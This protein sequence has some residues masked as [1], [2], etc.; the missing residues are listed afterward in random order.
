[1]AEILLFKTPAVEHEIPRAAPLDPEIAAFHGRCFE[2]FKARHVARGLEGK[3]SHK[4]L[5]AMQHLLAWSQ[6]PL[7]AI[8]ESDYEAWCGHLASERR[9]R[10][11]T[12]RTYQKGVR[13][14]IKYLHGS[15]DLQN[16][17]LRDF[18]RRMALFAHPDNSI[19]HSVEDESAGRLRPMSH[20]EI[21]I[22]FDS[23]DRRI[24]QAVVEAPRTVRSLCRD[25]VVFYV[26]YLYGLRVGEVGALE[27]DDWRPDPGLPECGDYAY[28]S[29][30]HGKGAKGS[31]KRHRI[32]PTTDVM[33]VDTMLWYRQ[34]VHTLYTAK[35]GHEN[36]VFL[37]EQGIGMS[38]S[39]IQA[40]FALHL[41]AAGFERDKFSPHSLRRAMVTHE[42][43]RS[44]F[45][46]A[47]EKVG[48]KSARTTQ[49]YGQVPHDHTRQVVRGLIIKQLDDLKNRGGE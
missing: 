12:Q 19:V 26:M 20:E 14:V 49:I 2:R 38:G 15:A 33:L 4:C 45:E 7:F 27:F 1:M 23:I 18:G 8:E 29:V 31:G 46:F 30:R 32:V 11:S 37:S 42:I 10:R 6:K 5:V 48:H 9:L 21:T 28:L 36:R 41:E 17:A 25:K 13:Q 22:L 34:D 35:S 43:M 47:R 44:S 16:E 3:Y 24:E 40:R 39:S